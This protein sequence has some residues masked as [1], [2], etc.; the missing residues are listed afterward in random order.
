M[1][2]L[3][4]GIFSLIQ[5]GTNGTGSFI[6]ATIVRLINIVCVISIAVLLCV[7]II[8]FQLK[9][10]GMF[11]DLSFAMLFVAP[12]LLNYYK[13]Y[14]FAKHTILLIF[15][16]GTYI[17]TLLMKFGGEFQ[18]TIIIPISLYFIFFN[19]FRHW[20]FYSLLIVIALY[21]VI[22]EYFT[23]KEVPSYSLHNVID[24]SIFILTLIVYIYSHIYFLKRLH[25]YDQKLVSQLTY[26]KAMSE[27]S[28]LILSDQPDAI[29]RGL[30]LILEASGASRIYI[31][32]N[33]DDNLLTSQTYE[34]CAPG[35]QTEIDNPDLQNVSCADLGFARWAENFKENKFI[36]GN[37]RDFASPEKEILASQ[38]IKSVLALPIFIDNKWQGFIGFDDVEK[39]RVWDET[40]INLLKTAADILGLHLKNI[41]Y[42]KEI[43]NQ[44]EE[45][46]KVNATKDKFFSIV[47]HDLKGPYHSLIGF[48]E[49]ME[50]EVKQNNNPDLIE[51]SAYIN[52]GLR[53]SLDYLNN[54]LDWARLQTQS[55]KYQPSSFSLGELI[56][57]IS[58]FLSVQ[59][60][61]KKISINVYGLDNI[62][63]YADKNMIKTVLTNLVSNAIKFSY[64]NSEIIL[65][66]EC[67]QNEKVS[68]YIK[69]KGIGI[70]PKNQDSLFDIE[71][72]F[73]TPGTNNE[74]GTGLGLILCKEFI[75]I[76]HG[77][78]G[79]ESE[80]DRGSTFYISLPIYSN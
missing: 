43:L 1:S 5:S 46:K 65:T 42:K 56:N 9:T 14:D 11:F 34:A 18:F 51:Y 41:K 70:H 24:F 31:F 58:T 23:I 78:I 4:K 3:K 20:R 49:L 63:L 27:F 30:T 75:N 55:I 74:T 48:S 67:F 6:D 28:Q 7:S 37:V 62:S 79:V 57:E 8:E 71:K 33:S 26:E 66:S 64:P 16:T 40:S 15:I 72:S 21:L 69:D 2:K 61:N 52:Q 38:N 35:V 54:L 53:N 29:N 73:S 45:L 76:H 36:S 12:I 80:K 44:N 39:E 25:T 19:K 59:A 17:G 22:G 32:E 13:K 77:E 10:P 47:A 50:N 60:Q 68:I